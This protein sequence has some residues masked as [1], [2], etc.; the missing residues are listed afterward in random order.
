MADQVRRSSLSV[1]LN[2]A[3]GSSKQSDRDFNRFI[4]IALG[5]V[6]ETIAGLEVSLELKLIS[7]KQFEHF[8]TSYEAISRQLGGFSKYLKS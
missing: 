1:V 6:D 5:S 2:V 7:Q 4:A 3:E 8:L